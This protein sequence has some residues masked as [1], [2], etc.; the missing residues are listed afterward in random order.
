[1]KN[2]YIYKDLGCIYYLVDNELC[3]MPLSR[4]LTGLYDG[5]DGGSVTD[6]S[7]LSDK[8]K[9]DVLKITNILK[10]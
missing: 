7:E 6:T 8:Q 4:N 1:M 9:Q 10:Q 2:F 3:Y 5:S